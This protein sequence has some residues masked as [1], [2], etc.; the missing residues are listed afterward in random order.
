MCNMKGVHLS[1]CRPVGRHNFLNFVG[2][3]QSS[4]LIV[5]MLLA[6]PQVSNAAFPLG[7]FRDSG[8]SLGDSDSVSVAS[9]DLDGDGDM[10]AFVVNQTTPDRV[11]LNDGTSTFTQTGQALIGG[12]NSSDVALGDLDG[13][14]DLDAFVVNSSTTGS[15]VWLNNGSGLFTGN[16]QVLG[17]SISTAVALA[18]LDGDGD[19][20][21]FVG[22]KQ[23]FFG[24][25]P[26]KVWLNDGTGHFTDSGQLLGSSSQ[27]TDI[28]L[29]DVDGDGDMDAFIAGSGNCIWLN[30]GSGIFT[31][32]GQNVCAGN[33]SV[34]LG[35]VD[36]DGD[37]DALTGSPNKVYFNNGSGVF[38]DSGQSLNSLIFTS[39]TTDAALG[40]F[41]KDGDLDAFVSN[42]GTNPIEPNRI[43]LNNGSGIF[44]DTG[45]KIS[46]DPTSGSSTSVALGDFDGDG[47][48]DA[49]VANSNGAGSS[50]IDQSNRVWLGGILLFQNIKQPL[51]KS[52]S[53]QNGALGDLDGDGDLDAY[54]TAPNSAG[55]TVLFNDGNGSFTPGSQSLGGFHELAFN[56]DID[57]DG[58]LDIVV[59]G[60][61][62]NN[63][64]SV[65]LNDGFGVFTDSGQ[66]LSFKVTSLGDLDGDGDL[67][68]TSF[69]SV[70][71]N[72]GFGTFTD[73]GKVFPTA[74]F[75]RVAA[76]GDVDGDG[77]LDAFLVVGRS[78]P[79]SQLLFNDG[80]GTFTDSGQSF[81]DVESA[82]LGDVD[83]DGDLDA[84]VTG[85]GNLKAPSRVLLN[86]GSGVFTDS[87][88]TLGL[89][90]SVSVAL[91]D[92]DGDGD[93]DALVGN[94][95]NTNISGGL[96]E[97]WLNSGG[98]FTDSG[99][100]L[101]QSAARIALG[102]L[103]GDGNLDAFVPALSG[104]QVWFNQFINV[105]TPVISL[106]GIVNG[107]SFNT[108][109]SG[110]VTPGALVSI[111]GLDMADNPVLAGSVPLPRSLGGSIAQINNLNAP[112]VFSSPLQLN[113]QIPWELEQVTNAPFTITR[114]AGPL[115]SS[116]LSLTVL[117][118]NP[119]IFTTNQSGSGQ[120]AIQIAN[121]SS[122]A[123]PSGAFPGSRPA[124]RGEFIS[125]FCTGLGPV[126]NTPATGAPA[127]DASSTLIG[128]V[129]VTIDG[130]PATVS[131]AGL[132]PG[133]V[134]LYQV[135]AQVPANA[136]VGSAVT[137][138]LFAGA[139]SNTVTIAVQ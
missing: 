124:S 85:F 14:G 107:G 69:S 97:V 63:N 44:T 10:D 110:G 55:D 45:Q 38:S 87:G 119:G 83:G 7:G 73:S 102:D 15:R 109:A 68:I 18:D 84:F 49:F 58:D 39:A 115:I 117:S 137:V 75:G 8:Q 41:D 92:I 112:L 88:Q 103:D 42:G 70:W 91:G 17:A 46:R 79:G 16:G 37:I 40:D 71:P 138:K 130:L 67:D 116:T 104:D 99:F 35:D 114:T 132:A 52:I 29:G 82:A 59:A 51:L 105:S 89:D 22:N 81:G 48:L 26:D 62:F 5:I 20:D 121:T 86:N 6:I 108:S 95:S 11:W 76:L 77:D 131:F 123:A 133:F 50:G 113:I 31:D 13:D 4:A 30:N 61:G 64:S 3:I 126:N 23:E 12:A 139:D 33:E 98:T 56:G 19:L 80:S 122:L 90:F 60:S 127:P 24:G 9:G 34:A 93:I 66:V 100:R 106:A 78:F 129:T 53:M 101:G 21:A 72:N 32:S 128:P 27:T 1:H 118:S 135:N 2:V 136:T 47:N 25:A 65:L 125:I 43:W 54:V 57:G 120:G 96:T 94:T 111:F 36:N 28:A 134:G 74:Q